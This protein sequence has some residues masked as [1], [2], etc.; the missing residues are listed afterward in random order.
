MAQ[1]SRALH[2]SWAAKWWG[3]S[4]RAGARRVLPR[5]PARDLP[6]P[7]ANRP[8]IL[9]WL[10]SRAAA[11]DHAST[12]DPWQNIPDPKNSNVH[13]H[14]LLVHLD[15]ISEFMNLGQLMC[16][17]QICGHCPAPSCHISITSSV[18]SVTCT[19]ST[20]HAQDQ[21]LRSCNCVMPQSYFLPN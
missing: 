14:S 21:A 7:T 5:L 13:G 10:P 1:Q 15:S 2:Y 9:H 18:I 20:R 16:P 17:N 8:C 12:Q 3:E 4:Q 19:V 6:V 11:G